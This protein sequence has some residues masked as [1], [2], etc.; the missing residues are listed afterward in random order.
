MNTVK[1]SSEALFQ[2]FKHLEVQIDPEHKAVWLY[3]NS[4]PRSCFTLT[5]LKELETFQSI[6]KHNDG[7]LSC[8]GELVDIEF[9]VFTSRHP[10]FSFGGDL[11]LFIN[12]LENNDRKALT[13]Y[14]KLCIDGLYANHIGRELGLT[15]ISLVHGNALGG[16]FE[17]AL[18]GHVLIAE[19]NAELGFP[20]V[21]FS[22]FPGM[23][24]FNLLTQKVSPATAEKM[25][26]SGRLY[27]SDELYDIGI[28]D[29][30]AEDGEGVNAVNSYIR[31]NNKRRK[32]MRAIKKVHQLVNPIDYQQLLDIADIWVDAAFEI[33][34][35]DLRTMSRLVR[36]Q[37]RFSV[38]NGDVQIPKITAS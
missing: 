17:C 27:S 38:Q 21:L 10:V 8:S 22:L 28:V 30:L 9:S 32:T 20:E 14:A 18:S 19:R 2:N 15:T 33:S 4:Q 37:Q 1:Y 12:C 24:A 6:L 11:E 23:G 31:A 35:R 3:L 36:S 5:L 13:N 29:V 25:M 34:D 16:G 26:I 7:K